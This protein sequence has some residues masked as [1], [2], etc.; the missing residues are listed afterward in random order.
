LIAG[1][2]D[3]L[4]IAGTGFGKTECAVL[5]IL[6]KLAELGVPEGA[7]FT[8]P[9]VNNFLAKHKRTVQQEN[10]DLKKRMDASETAFQEQSQKLSAIL[11]KVGNGKVVAD[12]GD[13][14]GAG[15]HRKADDH[16]ATVVG[17]DKR[18]EA[19]LA[20]LSQALESQ[21]KALLDERRKREEAE[22]ITGERERDAVLISAGR[23]AGL[24]E[25]EFNA[26]LYFKDS[27]QKDAKGAWVF[28]RASDGLMAES[29]N[30]LLESLQGERVISGR[31]HETKRV[32]GRLTNFVLASHITESVRMK[33]WDAARSWSPFH[34]HRLYLSLARQR[35]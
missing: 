26:P 30:Y 21:G 35:T 10:E 5:P 11:E 9:E 13:G 19:Q 20:K 16:S 31:W 2:K 24:N 18:V 3:V 6:S 1:G 4:V 34:C 15:D 25:P 12:G 33:V 22:R 32:Y 29:T 7:I 23:R 8:Q 17:T 14:T 27:L 28:M